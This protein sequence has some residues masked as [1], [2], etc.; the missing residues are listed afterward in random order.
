MKSG[1]PRLGGV[2][3]NFTRATEGRAVIISHLPSFAQ[4]FFRPSEARLSRPQFTHLWS[5]VLGIVLNLRAAKLVHLSAL[6][7]QGGHRTRCG[8][9][10]SHSDWDAPALLHGAATDLLASMKPRVGE[11]AY[12]ILDDTRLPKRGR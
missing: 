5:L 7:P 9:F 3:L 11:R 6:A 10:L 2:D 8:A 12:L 4:R 1:L